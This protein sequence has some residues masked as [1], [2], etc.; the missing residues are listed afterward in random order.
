MYSVVYETVR[1]CIF[2]LEPMTEQ[3]ESNK[4]NNLQINLK[5]CIRDSQ[6]L[7]H[8]FILEQPK[9]AID[10]IIGVNSLLLNI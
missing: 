2:W 1:M 7:C 5:S 8:F 4:N 6:N 10:G 9:C 3:N